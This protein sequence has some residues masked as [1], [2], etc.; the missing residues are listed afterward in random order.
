MDS[1]VLN[2][3][4]YMALKFAYLQ[5]QIDGINQRDNFKDVLDYWFGLLEEDNDD[6]E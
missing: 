3:D 2:V 1:E 6:D 5:G 4:I